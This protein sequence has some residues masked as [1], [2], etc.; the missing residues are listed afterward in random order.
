MSIITHIPEKDRIPFPQKL[1]FAVGQ[2][3]EY[4]AST[5]I[6][7][8]LWMPFFNI[9]LGI[10]PVV[11]GVVLMIMRAWDAI[12]DP[13]VGNLSDNTRTRW[14]RRRPYIFV[15][16]ITTALLFPFLWNFP[17]SVAD[18]SSFLGKVVDFIPFVSNSSLGPMERAAAVYLTIIGL[19]YFTSFTFWSMSYYGLQL[20]LTPNYDERTRLTALMTLIGKLTSLVTGWTFVTV[21]FVGTIAVGDLS[22]LEGKPQWMQDFIG[23][24]QPWLHS[25]ASEH[26]DEKPIVVGMKVLCW[27]AAIMIIVFGMLPSLFVKERYYSAE[28]KVQ[29]SEPFWKSMKESAKCGPLWSLISVSFFLVLGYAAIGSM[30]AYTNIYYVCGGDMLKAG[31]IGGLKGTITSLSGILLIPVFTMMGERFDKKIAVMIMLGTS[32]FGHLLNYFCMTPEMPYLQIIPAFFEASA[33]SAVWMFLPSMK[34]DVADWDEEKTTRRREGSINAFYSWFIKASL[35]LSMGISGVVLEF[36]GYDAKVDVQPENV[37]QR[38]F[39]LYVLLPVI[40]WSVAL[41]SVWFYPLD[42]KRSTELRATLEA[43]RGEI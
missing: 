37:L 6:T 22:M 13:L 41:I 2:N 42:R 26:V 15:A 43:R 19:L 31:A 5:L 28:A 4:V 33:I 16:S 39:L 21:V 24:I 9:G 30:G 8:T 7:S 10:S 29:K 14:G 11:L 20:E 36:S 34:A 3:T 23:G 17:D 35:T 25:F 12:S 40:I 1:A 18:G 27:F 38:M 32:M